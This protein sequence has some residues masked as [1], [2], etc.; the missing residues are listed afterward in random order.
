MLGKTKAGKTTS[1]HYLSHS[2]LEGGYND[3]NNVV[4]KLK[5]GGI[6]NSMAAIGDNESKS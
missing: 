4:Y 6:K 2:I 5:E 3:R 1:S